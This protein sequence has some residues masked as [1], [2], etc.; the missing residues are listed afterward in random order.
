[1]SPKMITNFKKKNLKNERKKYLIN[2][3]LNPDDEKVYE[4]I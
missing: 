2:L 4:Q 3:G 1:M